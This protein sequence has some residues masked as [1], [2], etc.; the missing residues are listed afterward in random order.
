ME[1]HWHEQSIVVAQSAIISPPYGV[2]D[3]KGPSSKQEV[4]NRVKKILEGERRKIKEREEKERRAA[5]TTGPRKG[6]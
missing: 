5:T 6:G 3:C 1:V 4:I 2:E